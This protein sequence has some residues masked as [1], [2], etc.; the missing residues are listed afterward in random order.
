MIIP[1]TDDAAFYTLIAD[2]SNLQMIAEVPFDFRIFNFSPDSE[3]ILY[4]AL[5]DSILADRVLQVSDMDSR[6]HRLESPISRFNSARLSPHGNKIAFVT[7]YGV[8]VTNTSLVFEDDFWEV[9]KPC[10]LPWP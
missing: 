6:C 4:T 5:P 1:G 3:K 10:E 8:L 7:Y 2:G 9:G